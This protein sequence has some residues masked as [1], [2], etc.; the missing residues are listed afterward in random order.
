M[1]PLTAAREY[2]YWSERLIT[3]VWDDNVS[4][5]PGKI[6]VSFGVPNFNVQVQ[7]QDPLNTKAARAAS[8]EALLADLIVKDLDYMGPVSFLGGRSLIVL[9][10]LRD[11]SG[12]NNGAVTL[13]SDLRSPEG[14]RIAVCLFGS[15]SNVCGCDPEPPEWRKH[16]WTSSSNQGVELLLQA[17]VNAEDSNNPDAFWQATADRQGA[18]LYD[19]CW[20]AQNI[21]SRQGMTPGKRNDLAWHRGYTIGQYDNAEWLAR[22]YFTYNDENAEPG[23]TLST[24]FNVIHVGAALWMRTGA[25]HAW[26]PYTAENIARLDAAQPP[27]TQPDFTTLKLRML[28][29]RFFS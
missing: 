27:L 28:K 11:S 21:C 14:K 22:I 12:H 15:G 18:D 20:N 23:H 5:Q 4:E 6:S 3:K 8:T 7:Q 19:I 1:K 13:F 29:R 10:S 24:R 25:P 26:I 16:G 17:G 2:H 9:S